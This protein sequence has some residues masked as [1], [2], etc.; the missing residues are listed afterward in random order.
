MSN[1]KR[2]QLSS[3]IAILE[4]IVVIIEKEFGVKPEESGKYY[5]QLQTVYIDNEVK[6]Y[7]LANKFKVFKKVLNKKLNNKIIKIKYL[8]VDR[9]VK[10]IEKIK[11]KSVKRLGFDKGFIQDYVNSIPALQDV[12]IENFALKLKKLKLSNISSLTKDQLIEM[13]FDQEAGNFTKKVT[14]Y[15]D[16]T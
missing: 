4:D 5:Y 6:I 12:M 16:R 2:E 7:L 14:E 3:L 9:F 13:L 15:L 8:T 11:N 10:V 1:I